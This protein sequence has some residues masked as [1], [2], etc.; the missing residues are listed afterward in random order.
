MS[1]GAHRSRWWGDSPAGAAAG[2][3]AEAGSTG[4]RKEARRGY[5]HGS[6]KDA[7]IDAARALIDRHG[8][9]GFTLAQAAKIAG[10]TPAAPYRH[11]QDRDDLMGEVAR[12]GFEQFRARLEGAWDGG[13]PDPE[14]ALARM[15][16]AYLAFAREE[17]GFYFTM[18]GHA[19]RL[20]PDGQAAAD[21]AFETLESAAR[22][23]LDHRGAKGGDTRTL[24][25]QIW[26]HSHGVAM[27]M[28]GRYLEKACDVSDAEAL[29]DSGV[30]ALLEQ[31]VWQG[32]ARDT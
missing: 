12:R 28:L 10:V 1:R 3:E 4:A 11:F 18:F 16:R 31:A 21:K 23:V 24:A 17:P 6:L 8:P 5:H 32:T 19:Q 25:T 29:L 22:A 26:A 20:G 2:Q 27:L 9:A 7:L 13:R 15:G 30:R 14:A